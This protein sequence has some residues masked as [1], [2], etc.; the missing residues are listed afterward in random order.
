MQMKLA[1]LMQELTTVLVD[2]TATCLSCIGRLVIFLID[3]KYK[4]LHWFNKHNGTTKFY[5]P[6]F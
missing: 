4:N 1:H 2:L 6:S 5:M 3:Y